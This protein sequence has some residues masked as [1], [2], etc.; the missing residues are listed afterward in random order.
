MVD[1]RGI[2]KS[3]MP[4]IAG[5]LMTIVFL[6]AFVSRGSI[7]YHGEDTI[8]DVDAAFD[9]NQVCGTLLFVFG[10]ILVV[11]AICAFKRVYWGVTMIAS[12]I[13]IL[14]IGPYYLSRG[15]FGL[16]GKSSSW[17]ASTHKGESF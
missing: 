2:K 16:Q 9:D 4:L 7:F 15:K 11:G 1:T 3:Y 8:G 6:M 12:L 17:S 13:G 14:T 5:V 10:G